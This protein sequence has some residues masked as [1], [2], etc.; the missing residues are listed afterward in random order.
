MSHSGRHSNGWPRSVKC[1]SRMP[2]SRVR[3]K[4]ARVTKESRWSI[5]RP[6]NTAGS[7]ASDLW[8]LGCHTDL[9]FSEACLTAGTLL[10]LGEG[11]PRIQKH[12][13]KIRVILSKPRQSPSHQAY[14]YCI[15][16]ESCGGSITY[17]LC[18]SFFIYKLEIIIMSH[19]NVLHVLVS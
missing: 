17:F 8:F 19:H 13:T 12:S 4:T 11:F 18:F 6:V 1:K 7:T 9:C 15:L 16:V 2:T 5:L 10:C 14:P 3:V